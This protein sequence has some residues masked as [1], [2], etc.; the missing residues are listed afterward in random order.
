MI[1]AGF[2]YHAPRSIGDAIKLLGSLGPDAK[3][4]AGGH[5]LLPMMK[6][7]F[8]QPSALIDLRRIPEL[9]GIKQEGNE[10]CIGAMTTENDLLRSALL[11][12][13]VPLLVEGAGWIGDPQV[14]YKGTIGGDISHGDPGND[15][16]ALML[17]L[18]ASFVLSGP[19]GERVVKADGFFLGLYS[20]Q[21]EPDEVLTQIRVPIPTRR[22]RLVVPE[23]QAQDRRLCDSG[24]RRP[25]ANER[26]TRRQGQHWIDQCRSD[27][28]QGSRG[29]NVP[30][31]QTDRRD[32]PE[33]GGAAG[34]E[35]LQPNTGSAW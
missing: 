33:R 26:R 2:D 20:T 23:T 27:A 4:L 3:L 24:H 32:Q 9:R 31:R 11:A 12:D 22:Q 18:D 21:A 15:H 10:I 25:A 34:D 8:A 1:P 19:R 13:K 30:D 14:R 6:L 5:S 16:P 17:A 29:G 28:A 35:H 7:R